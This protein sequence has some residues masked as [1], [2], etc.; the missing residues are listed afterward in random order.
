MITLI[1]CLQ[2]TDLM[3]TEF[4]GLYI[5][6]FLSYKLLLSYDSF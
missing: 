4:F 1:L 2:N 3:N 5:D 6:T